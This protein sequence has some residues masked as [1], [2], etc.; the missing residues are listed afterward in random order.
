MPWISPGTGGR[1]QRLETG[2]PGKKPGLKMGAGHHDAWVGPGDSL[3]R[4][5][6]CLTVSLMMYEPDILYRPFPPIHLGH[7]IRQTLPGN[8]WF[9]C[10]MVRLVRFCT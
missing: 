4:R 10:R 7:A 3:E 2:Q 8:I 6:R 1:S 9:R 5:I